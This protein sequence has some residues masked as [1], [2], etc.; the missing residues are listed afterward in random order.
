MFG[1]AIG[2][3]ALVVV[4]SVFNGLGDVLRSVYR[5]Y[6]AEF[7]IVPLEGKSFTFTDEQMTALKSIEGVQSISRIIED[8]AVAIYRDQQ[9]VVRLRGV[10]DSFIQTGKID[11]FLRKGTSEIERNGQNMAILGAG[12]AYELGILLDSDA[13]QIEM[14]YPRNLRPGAMPS[15]NS[16]RRARLRPSG[17]IMVDISIDERLLITSFQAVERLL[18]YDNRYTA[19]ELYLSPEARFNDVEQEAQ[20]I[21]GTQ[22]DILDSDEQ[23]GEIMRAV[24]FEKLF[25]YIALTFITLIA[26]FNIFFSLSMLAIEKRRD[27]AVL[28]AVGATSQMVK[29]IFLKQG[30]IIAFIGALFGLILGLT[31]CY[32]QDR[33]GLVGL[34]MTNAVVSAY[35]VKV[36][37]TDLLLVTVS[38]GL[39]TILT[40]YRPAMLASKLNPIEFLD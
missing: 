25:T 30:L 23:H 10:E 35:P 2:T 22:F 11:T 5:T 34:G 9:S 39:I 19:V 3:M 27:M 36:V 7:K 15:T 28:F 37:W 16:V 21:V 29:K 1:V 4:L 14:I 8:N 26:S 38:I 31:L 20:Q 6:D 13:Y 40:S 17:V 33:Y 24:K 18:D 32:L 12:L